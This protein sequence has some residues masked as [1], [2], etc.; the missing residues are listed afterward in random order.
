MIK[1]AEDCTDPVLK[2]KFL[3]MSAY[4]LKA[5]SGGGCFRQ[6]GSRVPDSE[7]GTYAI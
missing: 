5:P 4:W 1:Y 2:D 6:S 3:Q 7:G